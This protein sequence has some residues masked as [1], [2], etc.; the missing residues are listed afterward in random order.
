MLKEL[1]QN[2]ENENKGAINIYTSKDGKTS[3]KVKLEK[4]T[5]WLSQEQIAKLFSVDRTVITKHIKNVFNDGEVDEKSNVQKV[6]F[7]HSDRPIKFYNLDIILSVG[8]RVNTSRGIHFRR[9]VSEVLKNYLVKGFSVNK[10]RLQEKGLEEF[11]QAVALIKKTIETK[12]LST[13]ETKGLLKI[14]TD[15]SNSWFL[16]Y[17][18]DKGKLDIPVKK[19]ESKYKITP[20]DSVKAIEVLKDDLIR[21]GEASNLFGVEREKNSI[22][23]IIGNVYQNFKG[24]DFYQSIE[25]KAAHLLYFIIKD[26]VLI[27][28]NK[29]VGSFLFIVFLA[30]NNFL[31]KKNGERKINDNML[32]ALALLIAKSDTKQK[33]LMIKLIINFLT[34]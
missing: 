2:N 21:K 8:Y 26:H 11:E 29:R 23:G 4:E 14:I 22:S 16:F 10:K 7:A 33:D 24:K 28:G 12:K 32:V 15:Y 34:N 25:E 27:D 30:K 31:L 6:H 5:V 20:E 13:S 1:E 19:S 3:L 17:K 9:W 18:Y